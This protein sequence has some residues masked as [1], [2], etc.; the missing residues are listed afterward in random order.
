MRIITKKLASGLMPLM[1]CL[2]M[3]SKAMP[4][5]YDIEFFDRYGSVTATGGFTYDRAADELGPLNV[6]W[7]NNLFVD[8]NFATT[9]YGGATTDCGNA[10]SNASFGFALL[11]QNDCIASAGLEFNRFSWNA[12]EYGLGNIFN[13]RFVANDPIDITNPFF[14]S[15]S[16][17]FDD[18]VDPLFSQLNNFGSGS[19]WVSSKR[20][21]EVSEPT[22][23]LL[24]TIGLAS[25]GLSRKWKT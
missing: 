19:F 8:F 15:T 12:F 24:I 16:F 17:S 7:G 20:E 3:T 4:V 9:S 11:T 18:S 25:L 13:L 6:Q 2:P 1:L 21:V 14:P 5:F 10:G 23:L 22:S